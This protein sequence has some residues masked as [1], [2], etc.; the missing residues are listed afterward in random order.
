M[1]L[2]FSQNSQENNCVG[3]YF[4]NKYPGLGCCNFITKSLQHK[5]FPVNF[6]KV[7]RAPFSK[8]TS[9]W[10]LVNSDIW[11]MGTLSFPLGNLDVITTT[12][13]LGIYDEVQYEIDICGFARIKSFETTKLIWTAKTKYNRVKVVHFLHNLVMVF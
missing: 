2:K 3:V 9:A 4:H 10:L 1:L 6:A 7:L 8:S 13:C 12:F 11:W 5:C